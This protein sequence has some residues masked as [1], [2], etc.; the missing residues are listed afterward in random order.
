MRRHRESTYG[1]VAVVDGG[2][3]SRGTSCE[4]VVLDRALRDLAE[5]ASRDPR[6][7]AARDRLEERLLDL[8]ATVRP[9]AEY[10][11]V[12]GE[13]GPDHVLV[14]VNRNPVVI[15]IEG[16]MYFD[17][18]WEHVFLRIRLDDD[19]Y[20]PL[21]GRTGRAPARALPA[22]TAS[23]TDDGPAA[24]ARRRLP[25]PDRH[26]GNRRSQPQEGAGPGP[27]LSA[28]GRGPVSRSHG[29][30]SSLAP[31]WHLDRSAQVPS[32]L[33]RIHR[34]ISTRVASPC[35]VMNPT[36]SCVHHHWSHREDA[37]RPP[38]HRQDFRN[39][40]EKAHEHCSR[41]RPGT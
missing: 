15:D 36:V 35:V 28:C 38:P 25:P 13:L 12:H 4:G 17:V 31:P 7:A 23:V 18:E 29:A 41:R 16:L 26:G 8:A 24:A 2:G 37:C 34:R 14:D 3:M 6:I 27:L 39:R 21:G 33:P 1:K 10:A 30:R 22:R 11:A 32:P 19:P 20:R 5:A 40:G 9:R